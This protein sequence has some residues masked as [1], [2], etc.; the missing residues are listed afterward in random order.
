MNTNKCE[1]C[2]RKT[3]NERL[4]DFIRNKKKYEVEYTML[5]YSLLVF[6]LISLLELIAYFALFKDMPHFVS[7][8]AWWIFYLNIAVVALASSIWHLKSYKTEVTMMAGMMIG[9]TFGMQTGMMI[10][11][12]ITATNGLITGGLIGMLSAVTVGFYNGKCCGIMGI[13]EGMMAGVM[14]GLMGGMIGT[15]FYV[16]HI[17]LLMPFFMLINVLIMAGLSYMLYEEMV[18]GK[19]IQKTPIE[20]GKLFSY[21]LVITVVFITI[22]IYGPKTGLPALGGI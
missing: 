4:K 15:M 17:L 9:M 19:K 18:E 12:I 16:D 3:I 6:V 8:Y 13:L 11:T 10:G 21:S 20:F 14:G 2:E 7:R 22:M 5:R 1:G